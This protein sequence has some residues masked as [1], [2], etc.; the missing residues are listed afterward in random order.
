VSRCRG[1]DLQGAV[2]M[3]AQLLWTFCH[4]RETETALFA[5][6]RPSLE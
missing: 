6:I 1:D 4:K 3:I 2:L 5:I